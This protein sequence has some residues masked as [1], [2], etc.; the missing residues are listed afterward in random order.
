G[1]QLTL[2]PSAT[3]TI[4]LLARQS[5]NG[6]QPNGVRV[7]GGKSTTVWTVSTINLSDADP[8]NVPGITAPISYQAFTNSNISEMA[9]TN[10]AAPGFLT[11]FDNLFRESG[12]T[13]GVS[14]N[15]LDYGSIVTKQAL[16]DTSVLHID[17]L[18]PIHL[19]AGSG[20]ISGLTLFSAKSADVLAGR[21]MTDIAFY[22]Q[23]VQEN[24]VS[25]VSAGRDIIAY[26]ASSI[27]RSSATSSG[28]AI[29]L[30]SDPLAGDIQINGPGTLEVLAGR[31]LDLGNAPISAGRTPDGTQLGI[32]SIG[33]ARNPYL[34]FSGAD[35]I[36]AAGIGGPA[37]LN[38]NPNLDLTTF[39]SEFLKSGGA[40]G[41]NYMAELGLKSSDISTLSREE[42]AALAVDVFFLVLRDAG[43]SQ[44]AG[45][46]GGT[47]TGFAAI[48][49]LFAGASQTGNLSLTSREIKTAN[50]GNIQVL[51]PN[52]KVTVG[53]N[54]V[55]AQPLDQGIIT[56]S[57]G[58]IQIFADGDI[59][60]GTSRIF[61]LRGGNIVIWSTNGSIAAG[62]ASKTVK[63]A[64]PTRVL[65]DPQ[66]ADVKTDLAGLAT[67]GG[68]GVLATV[69]DVPPGNVDLIAPNGAVDAGD[70]GIRAS[71]NLNISATKVLNADN[72]QVAGSS[73]GTPAA[74][75]PSAPNIGGLT[76]GNQSQAAG[77]SAAEEA[78]KRQ[79][80]QTTQEEAPPSIITVEVLGYGGGEGSSSPE[81]TDT[82]Q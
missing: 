63:S 1:G 22:I 42:Q 10:T 13:S 43:R 4:D 36:T 7:S 49:K 59:S 26:D 73:T 51:V 37:E 65:I 34:P 60:L 47:A 82:P 57:G 53:F 79:Q 28:D 17:D 61:T 16:H 29:G 15:G 2:S 20:D 44:T 56:E 66:S 31:N 39:V 62:T 75:A 38:N 46:G 81:S 40:S 12:Q 50:G 52:G 24:A 6:L 48:D 30:G 80:Q 8:A 35:I 11:P 69:A 23:N 33:N 76:A 77:S 74:V 5:I 68:I 67:G 54:V 27:L 3:G 72:I 21:D 14:S 64:P 18:T 70:A 58:N 9:S 41:T 45:T 78:A 71:G 32:V 19:Y 55:G 25:V